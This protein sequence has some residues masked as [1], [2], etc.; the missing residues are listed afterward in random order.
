MALGYQQFPSIERQRSSVPRHRLI[1]GFRLRLQKLV[2]LTPRWYSVLTAGLSAFSAAAAVA[3]GKLDTY[4]RS[5]T[6]THPRPRISID[7]VIKTSV[8][9]AQSKCA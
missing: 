1:K 2:N 5:S 8:N 7:F 4:R 9:A 3:A 6:E